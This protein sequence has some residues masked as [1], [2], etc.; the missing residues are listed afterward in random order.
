MPFDAVKSTTDG[1]QKNLLKNGRPSIK[2]DGIK[3]KN[4]F[5]F[6]LRLVFD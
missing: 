6:E 2:A 5:E 3:C 1:F 4:W